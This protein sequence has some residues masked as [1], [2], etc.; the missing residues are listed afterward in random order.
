MGRPGQ[1]R[2]LDDLADLGPGFDSRSGSGFDERRGAGSFDG[3]PASGFNGRPGESFD[4]RP[5]SGF[6][7]RPGEAF[8]PQ[9]GADSWP[10][11]EPARGF[12]GPGRNDP[13]PGFNGQPRY[14]GSTGFR[15][16][17]PRPRRPTTWRRASRPHRHAVRISARR[18]IAGGGAE[19]RWAAVVVGAQA[20]SGQGGARPGE[21]WFPDG[22]VVA[23][24]PGAAA[25]VRAV[26]GR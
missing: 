14:P 20:S 4:G 13:T 9:P 26:G 25:G 24:Q 8:D 10:G 5:A 1:S 19:I 15:R 22:R 18:W 11:P 23:G 6:N 21:R 16:R 17:M 2:G 12:N 7:G 3:R